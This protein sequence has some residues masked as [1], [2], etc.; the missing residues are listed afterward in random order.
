M[1]FSGYAIPIKRVSKK[2]VLYEKEICMT[3]G[4]HRISFNSKE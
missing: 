3:E 2:P 4:K 1:Y